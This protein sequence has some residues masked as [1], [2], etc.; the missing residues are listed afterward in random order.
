M[1]IARVDPNKQPGD[2]GYI[3]NQTVDVTDLQSVIYYALNDAKPAGV[4]YNFACS[5]TNGDEKINV[6]D[7]VGTVDHVLAYNPPAGSRA[8]IYNKVSDD[9][10]N[11]LTVDGTSLTLTTTEPVAAIQLAVDALPSSRL[12]VSDAIAAQFSVAV[13]EVNGSLRIVIYSPAGQTLPAGQH[14][15]LTDLPAGATITDVCLSNGDAQRL[16]VALVGTATAVE[17]VAVEQQHTGQVYDL[18]G[19]PVGPWHTL[20][21]GV[22]IINVNGNQYKD[23]K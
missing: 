9:S 8:R 13:R 3:W 22:Y 7:I 20:P 12:C 21:R 14:E 4:M 10:S 23:K 6:S 11:L 17:S 16:S 19:R 18:S 5:D 1:V 2:E 15:L